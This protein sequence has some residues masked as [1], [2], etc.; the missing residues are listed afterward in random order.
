[1]KQSVFVFVFVILAAVFVSRWGGDTDEEALREDK[2]QPG[3]D[4]FLLAL[5]WP[6]Q[7]CTTQKCNPSTPKQQQYFTIHG[8]W[9]QNTTSA[10]SPTF[11]NSTFEFNSTDLQPMEK[12]LLEYWPDLKNATGG[13]NAS[14]AFWRRVKPNGT[15]YRDLDILSAV[16]RGIGVVPLLGSAYNKQRT[17]QALTEI[18][19]CVDYDAEKLMDCGRNLTFAAPPSRSSSS[20]STSGVPSVLETVHNAAGLL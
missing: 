12:K 20:R 10:K 15:Q 14:M 11:C 18:R 5:T 9:P 1:M 2:P 6:N 16:A 19:L 7:F 8:L 4:Y 13:F 3:Y 17:R